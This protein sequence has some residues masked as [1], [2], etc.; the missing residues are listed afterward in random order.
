MK[1]TWKWTISAIVLVLALLSAGCD[2]G[3][4]N[5]PDTPPPGV[6]PEIIDGYDIVVVGVGSSGHAAMMAA[7]DSEAKVIAIEQNGFAFPMM[8]AGIG[9]VESAQQKAAKDANNSLFRWFTKDDLFNTLFEYSHYTANGPL[10]RRVVDESGMNLDWLAARGLT[11]T[12]QLGSDQG[13]HIS[14]QYLQTYHMHNFGWMTL[15]AY[16]TGR[17]GTLRL[18]TRAID[19]VMDGKKVVGVLAEDITDPEQ[20]KPLQINAKKV[21]LCTGGYGPATEKFKELLELENLD[22]YAFGGEGNTGSGIE[23]AVNTAG[24][25]L[26]GDHSFM[27]HNNVA[28]KADGSSGNELA[29][30]P[31]F[32]LYN[33]EAIPCVNTEGYR[34]MNEKLVSNSALWANAS[35]SQGGTYLIVFDQGTLEY[36]EQNGIDQN[37]WYIGAVSDPTN[38]AGNPTELTAPTQE[39]VNQ[40]MAFGLMAGVFGVNS[41]YPVPKNRFD[42]SA[43]PAADGNTLQSIT[44]AAEEFASKDWI[45]KG[46]TIPALALDAGMSNPAVLA[47]TIE[48]YNTA[49]D[50][51]VDTEFGKQAEYLT[52]KIET[53]PFYA[54]RLSLS[55]LGGSS[56]GIMVDKNLQVLDNSYHTIPGLYAAGLNAGGFYGPVSTYYDYEGSAM[57][58]ATNSGRIAGTEAGLFLQQ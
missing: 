37:M 50:A 43:T 14:D 25:K 36:L 13:M 46:D 28:R 8:S 31:L 7:V 24:A 56:G 40:A 35:Y 45:Y 39:A 17:G 55:S 11:T 19:L 42:G 1:K 5:G 4:S 6:Q 29:G 12:L 10:L 27:L 3:V 44:D 58:F 18:N 15:Q 38:T 53:G 57:M 16:F 41:G 21:I 9:A 51:R 33:W 48:K 2:T 32:F 47:Q 22:F 49:V 23:M 26:W 20:H 54:M 34:F 30:S 52:R